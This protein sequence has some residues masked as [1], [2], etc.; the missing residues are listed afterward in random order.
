MMLWGNL[1]KKKAMRS[2]TAFLLTWIHKTILT[3]VPWPHHPDT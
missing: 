2:F 1:F 3:A